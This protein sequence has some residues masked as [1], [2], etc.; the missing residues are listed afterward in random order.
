MPDFSPAELEKAKDIL[1]RT[2]P[3]EIH[4]QYLM[5]NITS[6]DRRAALAAY[7]QAKHALDAQGGATGVGEVD[8]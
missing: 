5:G 1:S 2:G 3:R 8:A 4:D 7:T 6:G